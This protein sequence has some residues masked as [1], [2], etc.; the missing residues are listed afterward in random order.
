MTSTTESTS[1][2]TNKGYG[3]A[4]LNPGKEQ[5]TPPSMLL[6]HGSLVLVYAFW[7]GGAFVSKFG[8][9]ESSPLVFEMIREALSA[10]L[11]LMLAAWMGARLCPDRQDILSLLISVWFFVA[12]QCCFFI[13]LKHLDSSIAATYQTLFPVFATTM[14]ILV[15]QE[16]SACLKW[17]AVVFATGGAFVMAFGS[18]KNAKSSSRPFGETLSGHFLFLGQ[19][20]CVSAF[21]VFSKSLSRKYGGASVTSWLFTLGA[22]LLFVVHELF[23]SNHSLHRYICADENPNV[24]QACLEA[25][26]SIPVG[27]IFPLCYEILCCSFGGWMI[28]NWANKYANASVV[29]VYCVVQPTVAMFIAIFFILAQGQ[30]VA[31]KFGIP[32][33][34]VYNWVGLSLIVVGLGVN[35]LQDYKSNKEEET[36]EKAEADPLVNMET[37]KGV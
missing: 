34:G 28:L 13:G 10:P 21:V 20:L 12:G 16:K 17:V 27:M 33:P 15:G 2:N 31:H 22:C 19:M 9:H 1:V 7:G 36:A 23:S 14:A 35:F 6:I 3:A 29:S 30:I 4:L 18:L 5:Q 26:I 11:M 25:K 24:M 32:M 8:I 37:S